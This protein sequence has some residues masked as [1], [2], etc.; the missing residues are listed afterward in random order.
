[1]QYRIWGCRRTGPERSWSEK[2]FGPKMRR[3]IEEENDK[4]TRERG[5]I[6]YGGG[7]GGEANP[8]EGLK[9]ILQ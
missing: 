3:R 8:M 7:K 6:R 4:N 9:V 1:M 2:N 5:E